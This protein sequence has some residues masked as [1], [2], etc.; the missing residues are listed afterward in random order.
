MAIDEDGVP[1]L[2]GTTA[3]AVSELPTHE[4]TYDNQTHNS[5][6]AYIMKFDYTNLTPIYATYLGG[7]NAENPTSME[8]GDDGSIY[9]TG[10]TGSPDFPTT[11]GCFNSIHDAMYT[12]FVSKFDPTLSSLKFSTFIHDVGF[13]QYTINIRLAVDP[14]GNAIISGS[15]INDTFPVTDGSQDSSFGGSEDIYLSKLNQNG[16]DLLFST[17]LGGNEYKWERTNSIAIDDR[18]YIFIAGETNSEDFPVTTGC[19]QDRF[20]GGGGIHNMGDCFISIF[21]PD[22]TLEYSTYVGGA[23]EE[24]TSKIVLDSDG[25]A[26]VAG[27]FRTTPQNFPLIPGGYSMSGGE[28]A[29]ALFKLLTSATPQM[30]IDSVTPDPALDTDAIRLKG[31]AISDSPVDRYVWTVDG[32]EVY[33]GT[34]MNIVISPQDS[35]THTIGFR[36][37]NLAG[38]W[39]KEITDELIVHTRPASI[40]D[41]IIP[42]PTLDTD[43]VNLSGHGTDD[44]AIV[45]YSWRVGDIFHNSTEPGI[46]V[47]P[48]HFPSIPPSLPTASLPIGFRVRDNY[49]VWSNETKVDLL[50]V[51]RPEAVII[52][53][54]RT[55][56][57]ADELV[58]LT[59]SWSDARTIT[60]FQWTSSLEGLVSNGIEPTVDVTGLTSGTHSISLRILDEWG[61]WSNESSFQLKITERPIATINSLTPNPA[62]DIDIIEFMGSASDD[63]TITTYRWTSSIDGV[64]WEGSDPYFTTIGLSIGTHTIS[65]TTRDEHGFWSHQVTSQIVVIGQPISIIDSLTPNPLASDESLLLTGNGTDDGSITQYFWTSDLD[66]DLITTADVAVSLSGLSVG[67]HTISLR[68]RDDLGFW[69]NR[70]SILLTVHERPVA[71]IS[72]I[73]PSPTIVGTL[74]TFQGQGTDDGMITAYFWSSDKDG[75]LSPLP[76]FTTS[77]LSRGVHTI[78]LSVQD[79]LGCWSQP[80]TQVIVIMSRPISVIT[81]ISHEAALI[82]EEI[83]FSG[84]AID[85]G[86]IEEVMW[87]SSIDDTIGDA[88]IITTTDLSPGQHQIT[89]RAKD[90]HGL[91]S[92]EAIRYLTIHARPT[93]SIVSVEPSSPTSGDFLILTGKGTDDGE[94]S[95]Y[96]W[97]STLDGE[98]FNGTWEGARISPLS[99]GTHTLSLRV[100]DEH[101]VWSEESHIEIMVNKPESNENDGSLTMI[102]AAAF[103]LTGLGGILMIVLRMPGSKF[104]K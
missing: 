37:L 79:D 30:Y 104:E 9:I 72:N 12:I 32:E 67:I 19:F 102:I 74:I 21:T 44:G 25:N 50:V 70:T 83:T 99:Q 98:L 101:G 100:Q 62:L 75:E 95:R 54:N 103:V 81:N 96:Q 66:G 5:T 52:P 55:L 39:S 92:D 94:I 80:A 78:S 73:S 3:Y 1:Y 77:S 56:Y 48:S 97:F 43:P 15:T 18:G 41:S 17:Y 4:G 29:I 13:G 22:G 65:F 86:P 76:E 26:V 20:G 24:F 91:W 84:Y 31:H 27:Y 38:Y 49:G 10:T 88:R 16:T 71:T 69:S 60:Q 8:M 11:H 47:S 14:D 61:F 34:K 51:S 63:D 87:R 2:M 68:T 33:N 57:A 53:A 93:A 42:N 85:D 58:P 90:E 6:T 28:D 64:L 59:G 82:D 7:A 23:G 40:I 46:I 89:F 45:E 36:G 35:G